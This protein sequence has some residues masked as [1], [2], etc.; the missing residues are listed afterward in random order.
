MSFRMLISFQNFTQK[1]A[2]T[3]ATSF[4]LIKTIV[5]IFLLYLQ[6]GKPQESV[7]TVKDLSVALSEYGIHIDKPDY[8]ANTPTTGNISVHK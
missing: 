3:F 5:Y 4:N 6:K 8:F 2:F 1:K 7:L